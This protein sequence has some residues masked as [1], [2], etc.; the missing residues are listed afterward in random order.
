MPI[1]RVQEAYDL[2]VAASRF[3]HHLFV[4]PYLPLSQ[5][6]LPLYYSDT[7]HINIVLSS[8][9]LL[10]VFAHIEDQPLDKNTCTLFLSLFILW[11]CIAVPTQSLLPT[12]RTILPNSLALD[13][14]TSAHVASK[15]PT[16]LFLLWRHESR[17]GSRPPEC[18]SK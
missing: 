14:G 9:K 1:V 7:T 10:S 15:V 6:W 8:Y 11:E 17:R 13:L 16:T 2:L 3:A 5:I 4:L 18:P 12:R